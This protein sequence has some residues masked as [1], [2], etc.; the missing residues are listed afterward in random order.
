MLKWPAERQYTAF[1]KILKPTAVFLA[2]L[3]LAP[4]ALACDYPERVKKFPDGVYATRA[5]MIAVKKLVQS[6][7]ARMEAYLAC[8]E[9]REAE[10]QIAMGDIDED[11]K[12]QRSSMFDKKYNAAIEEMNLVAEQFNIQLRAY[13]ARNR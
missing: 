10:D 11:T 7:I 5:E 3:S 8:I 4:G 2:M 1:M 6:Y 12:R 9:A 13:N